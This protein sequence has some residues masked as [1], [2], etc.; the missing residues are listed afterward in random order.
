[1]SNSIV[2]KTRN[3]PGRKPGTEKTGG[4]KAG[5]LNK[6]TAWLK[7]VLEE[8]DFDWGKDFALSMRCSDYERVKILIELLPYLNP[9]VNPQSLDDDSTETSDIN[10]NI[11]FESLLE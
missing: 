2:E 1:M 5:T 3:K 9:K 7:S 11:N 10:V 8:N 6:R 4:R